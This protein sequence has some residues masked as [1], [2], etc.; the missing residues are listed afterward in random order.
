[1]LLDPF[2]PADRHSVSFL[3]LFHINAF[4]FSNTRVE[5]EGELKQWVF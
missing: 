4:V 3:Y 1:M 2:N 5:F